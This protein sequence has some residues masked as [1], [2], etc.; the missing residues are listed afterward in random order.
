MTLHLGLILTASNYNC[1]RIWLPTIR[2]SISPSASHVLAMSSKCAWPSWVLPR[3]NWPRS[4][5]SVLL[6]YFPISESTYIFPRWRKE[7]VY[8]R[9]SFSKDAPHPLSNAK[10]AQETK[11]AVLFH[12]HHSIFQSYALFILIYPV[13]TFT[14]AEPSVKSG[15]TVA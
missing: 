1:C 10:A 14:F 9:I 6:F 8:G 5:A 3:R 11:I 4:W 15:E 13:E 7:V 12:Y 2:R